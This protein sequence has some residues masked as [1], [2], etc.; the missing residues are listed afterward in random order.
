ML[1]GHQANCET[2]LRFHFVLFFFFFRFIHDIFHVSMP[3]SQIFPPS[4]SLTESIRLFY[5]SV[6]LLLVRAQIPRNFH[7]DKK[8]KKKKK[9]KNKI[10]SSSYS[11]P[12][13]LNLLPSQPP[14]VSPRLCQY[15]SRPPGRSPAESMA[16]QWAAGRGGWDGLPRVSLEGAG[17]SC[18]LLSRVLLSFSP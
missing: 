6:S 16:L 12:Q 1:D 4:P 2:Q 3:F 17:G 18:W 5:T 7:Q 10:L 11:Q 13:T 15:G 14:K 9:N 8:R